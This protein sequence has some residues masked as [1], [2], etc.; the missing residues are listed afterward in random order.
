LAFEIW[1]G[2]RERERERE[3]GAVVEGEMRYT[4]VLLRDVMC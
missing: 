2:E 4:L 3:D 1:R